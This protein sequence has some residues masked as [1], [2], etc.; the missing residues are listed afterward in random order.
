MFIPSPLNRYPAHQRIRDGH[1]GRFP[2]RTKVAIV[3][4]NATR[5]SAPL[6]DPTWEVWGLNNLHLLDRHGHLRA[7]RWFELHQ[8]CAQVASDWAFM[9]ALPPQ[10]PLYVPEPFPA[11]VPQAVPFPLDAILARF[12]G[13]DFFACTFAYQ[14]ALALWEGFTEIGLFGV[15][16]EKGTGRERSVER[17]SVAYWL[18]LARGMGVA[19]TLPDGCDVIHHPVRYG[20]QYREEIAWVKAWLAPIAFEFDWDAKE[21]PTWNTIEAPE[22]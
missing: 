1:P 19:V 12:P 5:Q 15:D 22:P 16:L 21:T 17:A 13:S 18:G 6:A 3:G 2:D 4:G 7:D 14:V 8:V 20:F 10:I 9:H 11:D